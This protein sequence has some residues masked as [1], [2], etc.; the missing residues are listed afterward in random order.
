MV[1]CKAYKGL[2]GREIWRDLRSL[3]HKLFIKSVK[4]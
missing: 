2:K 3:E 1:V 4:M